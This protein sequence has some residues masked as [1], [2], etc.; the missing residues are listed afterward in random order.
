MKAQK[1]SMVQIL[2]AI[3]DEMNKKISDHPE[4]LHAEL[5]RIRKKHKLKFSE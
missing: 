2:R 1:K 4:Q 5:K 3:R